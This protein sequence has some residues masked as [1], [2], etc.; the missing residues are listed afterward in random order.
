MGQRPEVSIKLSHWAL[1][2]NM[3]SHK[4]CKTLSRQLDCL[5][6]S[7]GDKTTADQNVSRFLYTAKNSEPTVEQD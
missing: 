5:P 3:K 1:D 6:L 2:F 7:F 4:V